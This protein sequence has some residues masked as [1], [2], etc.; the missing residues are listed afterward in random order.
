MSKRILVVDDDEHIRGLLKDLFES[1]G[2]HVDV[3]HDGQKGFEKACLE[4]YDLITMDIRMPNWDGVETILGLNLVDN[5]LKFLIISGYIE[6]IQ[7]EKLKTSKHVVGVIEKPF[8]ASKL[9]ETT[10][11]LLSI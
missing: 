1:E 7:S 3:A 6:E 9:L 10:N 11:K 4:H 2:Y 8:D 5:D